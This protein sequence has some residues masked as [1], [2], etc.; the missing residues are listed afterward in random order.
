VTAS[1]ED[2]RPSGLLARM[3]FYFPRGMRRVN[4]MLGIWSLFVLFFLYFPIVILVVW[5]FNDMD[6]S[7]QWNH[8][9]TRWYEA[10]WA[11]CT[12][13]MHGWFADA[14]NRWLMW[15]SDSA[16]WLH[17]GGPSRWLAG[18]VRDNP[19]PG[20]VGRQFMSLLG[21]LGA[22]SAK[23][24]LATIPSQ[25][26]GQISRLV[27]GLT[28][29]LFVGVIATGLSVLLGTI[30]AWI[31]FKYKYPFHNA[32]STLV[33]VPMIVPE[34]IMGVS[35][36]SFITIAAT[37]LS[38]VG[39][40]FGRG[41]LAVIIAHITFS[42]PFVMVTIQARLAGIDPA[43]EEAAMDLGA[44]PSIA[45]RKVIVPY[46]M[47]AIISGML[48]AFTLSLDDFIVT[49]FVSEGGSETLPIRIYG[50]IKQRPAMLHVVS[51]VMIGITLVMVVLSELI[52]RINR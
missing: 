14:G 7:T 41:Y 48:M 11:Q 39:I 33:A 30:S 25:V 38:S 27:E 32:L 29:S 52:K 12:L 44:T 34:I 43:L 19:E 50:A 18:Y 35:L 47:P 2:I 6:Y 3:S 8:A 26:R 20:W 1:I 49:Y 5:S 10:F 46:L 4:W 42:F 17:L 16:A 28:R 40:S 15:L 24:V 37:L 51:T 9:S 45:F 31:T 13:D 22:D 23:D 36:L 21:W